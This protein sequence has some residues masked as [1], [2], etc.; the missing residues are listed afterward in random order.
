M[1]ALN[2]DS[3]WTTVALREVVHLP[4]GLPQPRLQVD[5]LRVEEEVLV[6]QADL[7]ERLTAQDERGAHHPVDRPDARHLSTA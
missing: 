5:L 2:C 4:A 7:V 3:W 1:P 6:E